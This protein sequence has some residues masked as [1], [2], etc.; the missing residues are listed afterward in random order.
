MQQLS[1][2]YPNVIVINPPKAIVHL[3]NHVSMLDVVTS[4]KIPQGNQTFRVPN[5]RVLEEL[6]NLVN[7]IEEIGFKFLF[8]AKPVSVDGSAKSKEMFLVFNENGLK[9]LKLKKPFVMQEFV[10]HGR[11]IFKVYVVGDHIKCVKRKSLRI[12]LKGR[13]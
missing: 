2:H 8:I 7:S 6:E 5:E 4:M 9:K 10:N 1:L 3:H 11:V 13:H 12:Y